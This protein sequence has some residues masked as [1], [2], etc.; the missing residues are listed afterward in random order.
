M[1]RSEF[2]LFLEV[3]MGICALMIIVNLARF[4]SRGVSAMLLAGAFAVLG[5]L[6]LALILEAAMV[7]VAVL[8]VIV[9]GLLIGDFLIRSKEHGKT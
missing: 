9:G 7:L 6:F 5:G 4:G 2:H 8:G 3:A 1:T